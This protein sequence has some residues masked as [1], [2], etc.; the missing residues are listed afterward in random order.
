[1]IAEMSVRA[2]RQKPALVAML[3]ARQDWTAAA[4]AA[5]TQWHHIDTVLRPAAAS[6]AASAEAGEDDTA[7]DARRELDWAI[8]Q[9]GFAD[10]VADRARARAH[11][12]ARAYQDT[13]A[14]D[15][16]AASGVPRYELRTGVGG[17]GSKPGSTSWSSPSTASVA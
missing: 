1:M 4:L 8:W 6:A 12:A 14:A 2:D 5:E 9:V 11:D 15:G 7:V 16:G 10:E 3:D 17:G 13:V